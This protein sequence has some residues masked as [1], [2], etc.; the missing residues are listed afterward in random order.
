MGMCDTRIGSVDCQWIVEDWQLTGVV[1]WQMIGVVSFDRPCSGD[2][3]Y[4]MGMCETW[5]GSVDWQWIGVDWQWI[6]VELALIGVDWPLW[7]R[8]KASRCYAGFAL[9]EFL[10]E[11]EPTPYIILEGEITGWVCH[12]RGRRPAMAY[13]HTILEFYKMALPMETCTSDGCAPL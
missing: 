2:I 12:G 8:R 7:P 10:G 3:G 5:I 9:A 6:R 4:S 11:G 13:A 1:D